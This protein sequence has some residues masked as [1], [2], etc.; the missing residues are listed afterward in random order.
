MCFLRNKRLFSS[1]LVASL[2]LLFSQIRYTTAMAN[3]INEP[4]PSK[5][6]RRF[7]FSSTNVFFYSYSCVIRNSCACCYRYVVSI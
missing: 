6:P 1:S 2:A 7:S 5:G 3:T 4:A